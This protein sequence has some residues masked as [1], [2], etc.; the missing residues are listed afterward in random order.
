MT[1]LSLHSL[2]K[3]KTTT[4]IERPNTLAIS[5]MLCVASS[6]YVGLFL[7]NSTVLCRLGPSVFY[8]AVSSRAAGEATVL[9]TAYKDRRSMLC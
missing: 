2:A 8:P 3:R 4:A 9:K 7:N 6:K 5:Y 1:F